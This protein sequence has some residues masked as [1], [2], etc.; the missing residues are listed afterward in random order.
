MVVSVTVAV[1]VAV[2]V[3]VLLAMLL[4][5]F[6]SFMRSVFI[7]SVFIGTVHQ[8]SIAKRHMLSNLSYAVISTQ[9]CVSGYV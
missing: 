9:Y 2:T 6:A 7:R 8:A 1:A 4:A 3:A 5:G